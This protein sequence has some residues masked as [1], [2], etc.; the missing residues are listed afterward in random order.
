MEGDPL[1]KA[2]SKYLSYGNMGDLFSSL[3]FLYFRSYF[4]M[5]MYYHY[6]FKK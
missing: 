4:I 3:I 6:S 1:Y 5:K 2:L